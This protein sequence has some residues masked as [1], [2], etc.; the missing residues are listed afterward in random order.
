MGLLI[1]QIVAL[2]AILIVDR[3]LFALCSILQ[4]APALRVY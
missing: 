1:T 4:H 2:V 3:F